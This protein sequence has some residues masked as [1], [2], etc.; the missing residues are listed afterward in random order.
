MRLPIAS[1]SG[2]ARAKASS[3]PPAM[4]VS[5][6]PL[7]PPTPPE[8]GA[9]SVA[10]PARSPAACAWRALAT[11]IVEQSTTSA[12]RETAGRM[13]SQQAITW[14][15]AGNMVKIAS[16]PSTA[17]LAL[18]AIA[19]PLA[20]APARCASTRSKPMTAWPAL[21]RLAAIGAPMLPRPMNAI[22]A[23]PATLPSILDQS[24]RNDHPH[25]L[26]RSLEDL[27][28]AQVAHQFLDSVFGKIAVAAQQLQRVI[29][30]VEAGVSRCLL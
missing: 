28:H 24:A 7:A 6:P 9:S 12:L 8:T 16:A 10:A 23:I 5:V 19:T 17:A 18:A 14:R 27:M 11:S 20:S 15:P 25:D 29:G 22:F 13:S 26:V 21:T 2:L 30:G 1:S 3:A 4:K